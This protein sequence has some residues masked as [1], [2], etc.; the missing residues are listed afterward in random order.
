MPSTEELVSA[1]R[2]GDKSAFAELVRLYERGAVL[3][4]YALLR[5]F[6]TAQDV[7][8]EA[9]FCAFSKLGQLRDA[10]AFGPWLLQIVRRR[11]LLIRQGPRYEPIP[12]DI[13]APSSGTTPDWIKPFEDVVEQLGRLSEKD[14]TLVIMRHVDGRSVQEIA[15]TTGQPAETVRK[16]LY[17]A[18]QRLRTKMIEVRT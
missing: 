9:F 6:H 5:D 11:A 16:Q 10:A 12:A 14:R 15:A 4:S 13:P 7:A 18:V 2:R 17:R 8:Q 1:A 3:T